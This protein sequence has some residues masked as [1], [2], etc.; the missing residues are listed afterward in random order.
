[1]T[2]IGLVSGQQFHVEESIAEI[3][4]QMGGKTVKLEYDGRELELSTAAIAYLLSD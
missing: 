1:M 4:K 2:T 3:R